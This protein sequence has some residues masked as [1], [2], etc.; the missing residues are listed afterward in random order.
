MI[1][2][3][4]SAGIVGFVHSLSP[5]HW[6]PIVLVAKTKKWGP[7][8]IFL[9]TAVAACGHVL[10]SLF[11]IGLG[12][13]IGFNYFIQ[14]EKIIE[15]YSGLF[16]VVFGLIYTA[17]SYLT[18]YRCFG[19]THHGVTPTELSLKNR[20][21]W[22]FLFG[23]GFSPCIAVLPLFIVAFPK[24]FFTLLLATVFFMLGVL[25]SM[26]SASFIVVKGIMKLDHPILEHHG[27]LLTGFFVAAMGVV[28]FFI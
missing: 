8:K 20:E 1:L 11:I 24:G 7:Y 9:G 2:I 6:F 10:V 16:L 22:W 14:N 4:I 23:I 5:A 21:P 26:L 17:I 28:L 27:D 3:A 12:G 19:H 25:T 18:H 13:L 15:Q